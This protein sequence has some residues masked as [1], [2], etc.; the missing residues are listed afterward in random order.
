[1]IKQDIKAGCPFD[2]EDN[3]PDWISRSYLRGILT[4]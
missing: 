4:D 3:Y 2:E 1:M